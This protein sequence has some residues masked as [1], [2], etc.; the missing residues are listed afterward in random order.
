[1]KS[2]YSLK[3]ENIMPGPDLSP[4]KVLCIVEDILNEI[5]NE[6]KRQILRLG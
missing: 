4:D 3:G 2:I 5:Q 1:M 6:G